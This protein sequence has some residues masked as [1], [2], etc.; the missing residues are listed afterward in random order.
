MRWIGRVPVRPSLI[1]FFGA[2]AL[3]AI[4]TVATHRGPGGLLGNLILLGAVVAALGIRRRGLYLLIPLPALTYLVLALATGALHDSAN[5]T[6]MTDWGVSLLQWVG[7]GFL[8]LLAATVLVLLIWGART[9]ASRQLV[10]G[11]FPMSEQRPEARRPVRA[12][13][14][15]DELRGPRR[16]DPRPDARRN[17][18]DDAEAWHNADAWYDAPR[19]RDRRKGPDDRDRR[20][21]GRRPDRGASARDYDD[22]STGSWPVD[23]AP[24]GEISRGRRGSR[25]RRGSGRR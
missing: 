2:A 12:S 16:A 3:G 15:P 20:R 14:P 13:A 6:S 5:D 10:S 8:S 18:L 21:R 11:S 25:D 22:W 4:A 7:N 24:P 23:Q 19:D 1:F 17:P 9:L